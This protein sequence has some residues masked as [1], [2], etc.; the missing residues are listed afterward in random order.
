M[1]SSSILPGVRYDDPVSTFNAVRIEHT[2]AGFFG[3]PVG[4]RFTFFD[5]D[6][7]RAGEPKELAE[8]LPRVADKLEERITWVE[9]PANKPNVKGHVTYLYRLASGISPAR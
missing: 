4:D 9:F 7:F 3:T 6:V 2:M 1:P 8:I 5:A